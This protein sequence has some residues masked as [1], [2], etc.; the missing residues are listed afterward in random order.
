MDK[1]L[2]EQAASIQALV[3]NAQK[4]GLVQASGMRLTINTTVNDVRENRS[5]PL[6]AIASREIVIP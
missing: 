3:E 5:D 2:A 4:R 1:S 6:P